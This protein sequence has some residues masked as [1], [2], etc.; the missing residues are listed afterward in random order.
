MPTILK[1]CNIKYNFEKPIDGIDLSDIIKGRKKIFD[2]YL[3][4]RQASR[5]PDDCNS[6]VR[7]DRFKLVLT[8]KDTLLFD[9]YN[10]PQ[11]QTDISYNLPD[12]TT[13]MLTKLIQTNEELIRNYKPVTTIEAGFRDEK[14]FTLPVQDAILSGEIHYSSFHP[15]Q[16]YTENWVQAGDSI[17]WNLK[18]ALEGMF[19]V[20]LQYGCLVDFTGS[21]FQLK[22]NSGS[23]LFSIDD[24][25]ESIILP[26]RDYEK[27]SESVERTWNWLEVG[28]IALTEGTELIIL[29]I[30][31]IEKEEAG[32][33]KSIRFTRL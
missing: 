32:L 26:D 13:K 27:R 7:N 31:T 15:N 16:S 14:S 4:L 29:K 21:K 10:D 17:Y 19:K 8:Q 11:Q 18:V 6:S 30:I 12:I 2:R 1:L 28:N 5:V 3:F 24:P 20:E 25:F 23:F 9:M 33:I 22:S